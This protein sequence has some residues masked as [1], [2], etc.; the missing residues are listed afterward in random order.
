[1]STTSYEFVKVECENHKATTSE[2]KGHREI[3]IDYANK[4]YKY[5]GYIPVKMG[6]SGK[7]LTLELIFEKVN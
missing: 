1:M 6:P 7:V 3:I 5:V 2:L 4:G